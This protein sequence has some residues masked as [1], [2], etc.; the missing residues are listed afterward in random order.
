MEKQ[1]FCLMEE[2]AME[3]RNPKAECI[4]FSVRFV[5]TR[6]LPI[7]SAKLAHFIK[8]ITFICMCLCMYE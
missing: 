3:V 5:I 2:R 6:P 4:A 1:Y 7:C 8:I